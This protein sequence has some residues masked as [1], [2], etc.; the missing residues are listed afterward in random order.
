MKIT[1]NNGFH[2]NHAIT[3]IERVNLDFSAIN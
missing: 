1:Y 2:V 3:A